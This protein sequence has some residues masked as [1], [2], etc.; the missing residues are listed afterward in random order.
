VRL[1]PFRAEERAELALLQ[2]KEQAE[3]E[4]VTSRGAVSS[5]Q[6]AATTR[7]PAAIR[8]DVT[9]EMRLKWDQAVASGETL[10]CINHP[11]RE[12]TLRCNSCGAPICVRC[13]RRTP[14]GFR[15]KACI[16]AQQSVFYNSRWYDYLVAGVVSLIMSVVAA[17]M[18][19]WGGRGGWAGWWFAGIVSPIAGGIIGGAVH[20]AIG[21]RRGRWIW[22]VVAACIV[23]GALAMLVMMPSSFIALIIYCV[24]ATGAAVGVLRL[25][26][27]R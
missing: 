5:P 15:C 10:Y 8:P 21:R 2:Q 12:T 14:V 18:V 19:A 4:P 25:G 26:K 16:D 1:D 20:W 22:L 23:V 6:P 17:G 3:Q 7:A 27:A 11:Q 24:L 13:A 9:D